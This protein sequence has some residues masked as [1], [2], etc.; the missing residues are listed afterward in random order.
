[1]PEGKSFPV[2]ETLLSS[3]P[4]INS[5][6]SVSD[7]FELTRCPSRALASPLAIAAKTS[8]KQGQRQV[9]QAKHGS[10]VPGRR[11]KTAAENLDCVFV[12]THF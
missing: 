11:P 12:K 2:G 10:Q 7:L 1:M 4:P 6:V 8:E 9:C 3:V 5:L